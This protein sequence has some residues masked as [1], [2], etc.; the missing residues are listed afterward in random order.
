MAQIAGHV[1][2]PVG[3]QEPGRAVIEDSRSPSCNR[4]ARRASRGSRRE[5]GRN[6]VR[7]RAADGRRAEKSGLVAAVT[8]RGIE[9]VVV[10]HMARRAGR[11]RRGH[12]R[13]GQGKPSNAVIERRRSPARCRM[14]IG[15][16]HRREC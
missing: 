8:I 15:A 7:H 9:R 3:Q 11:R 6:M 10:A 1:G 16:I 5:P 14:A 12:V 2:V 4:V 13:S